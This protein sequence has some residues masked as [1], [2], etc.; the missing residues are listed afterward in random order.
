MQGLFVMLH[1]P[2]PWA[3]RVVFVWLLV[4]MSVHKIPYNHL[5]VLFM[6]TVC[7]YI[8]FSPENS[9]KI[10]KSGAENSPDGY[11][12]ANTITSSVILIHTK[13]ISTKLGKSRNTSINQPK[14]KGFLLWTRVDIVCTTRLDQTLVTDDTWLLIITRPM[15]PTELTT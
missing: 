7:M 8:S 3:F 2:A 15:Y 5:Y 9:F 10:S 1:P 13:H 12:Q 4:H 14:V 11:S 6:K